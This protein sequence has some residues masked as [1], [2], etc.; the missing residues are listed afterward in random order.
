MSML[1]ISGVPRRSRQA[2]H[3]VDTP[4]SRAERTTQYVQNVSLK[5]Q[6]HK[7][8]AKTENLLTDPIRSFI[9]KTTGDDRQLS[10][11]EVAGILLLV[12]APTFFQPHSLT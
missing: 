6:S 12:A 1:K 5:Y 3:C 11:F 2:T 9:R 4:D 10:R 8:V 7:N